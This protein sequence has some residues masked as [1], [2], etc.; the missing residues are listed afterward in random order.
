MGRRRQQGTCHGA[1]GRLLGLAEA[2]PHRAA[3][4]DPPGV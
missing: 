1:P 2:H 4:W 3:P